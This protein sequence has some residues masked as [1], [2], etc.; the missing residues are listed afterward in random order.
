[1]AADRRLYVGPSL[2]RLRRD[3]GLT[4]A[5]MAA[6]LEI[7]PSYVALLERNHRPLSAEL[8]LRL[9]QTYKLDMSTLAGGGGA[10]ETARLQGVLKDP[11][12]ADIDLPGLEVADL[13]A[14]F[15]GVMEALLRLYTTYQ[16]EQ[17]ALADRHSAE[18]R[19]DDAS[20]PVAE[21]RRFLAARRN[22]FPAL[23]DAAERLSQ[24]TGGAD[25]LIAYLKSRHGL[26]V[27]RLPPTVMVGSVRRLDHHRREVLLADDQD[28]ASQSFQ[29]A[30]Q[31]A[32]LEL[33]GDVDALM[34]EGSFSESA[35]RLTRRAL[36]S[37]A[38]AALLMPYTAFARAAEQRRYDVEAL[39]R[40][41]GTSFEQTAHRLTTLQKP[42]DER[43]PFFFIRVDEAG[44]VSKR[45]D[46]A[47]FPFARHGGGCPLWNVHQAFRTP[48]QIV[49]QWLELPDGQRFFSIARTVTAG[50]G[51]FGKAKVERAIALGCAAEHAHRLVYSQPQAPVEAT[52]IGVTC[53]LCHRTECVARSAPPIGRQILPDD[54][55][56]TGAPF[57]FSDS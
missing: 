42:G 20:D 51:G 53:R 10:E 29:L 4:Q 33:G 28:H 27:R 54:I 40:Q 17:L 41:F 38:A 45:L 37:Y 24:A 25:G 34:A 6:D 31:L 7:S 1:M 18:P 52:P 14:N 32:Y 3:R 21:S 26:R 47:G 46:G 13:A 57:G 15:P 2:R 11:M 16:E 5:D 19:D 30:L 23:D 22:S 49:T 48:R 35:E 43:L 36:A 12:F 55:R 56:R 9:A 39:G 44:N 50:G 8:L